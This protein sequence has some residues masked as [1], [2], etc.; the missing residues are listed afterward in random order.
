MTEINRFSTGFRS[1]SVPFASFLELKKAN[2]VKTGLKHRYLAS[3]VEFHPALLSY[4]GVH[5]T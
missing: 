4:S 3:E 1:K 2:K 5:Y